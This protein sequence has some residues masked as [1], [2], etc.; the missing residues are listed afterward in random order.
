MSH[1]FA[2]LLVHLRRLSLAPAKNIETDSALLSRFV[3]HGDTLAFELLFW[4]HGPMVW[5]VCRRFLGNAADAED[6]FQATFLVLA[7]KARSV[8]NGAALSGWLHRV[9]RHTALNARKAQS[10]R[11]VRER[12]T[13]ALSQFSSQGDISGEASENE[14][15]ALIDEEIAL[16]PEKFRLPL[17]LCDMEARTHESAAAELGCPLGTLNSRLARGREKLKERLARHGVTSTALSGVPVPMNLATAALHAVSR[18]PSA[19]VQALAQTVMWSLTL[20]AAKKVGAVMAVCCVL[21]IGIASGLAAARS[22]K[23]QEPT[24][25]T[26]FPAVA[27]A[28]PDEKLNFIDPDAGPLPADAVARIG[29]LRLRHAGEVTGLTYSP[30]GKWLA[31]ISASPNDATA[32]VWD[33]ANGKEQLRVKVVIAGEFQPRF[34]PLAF[35]FGM[36]LNTFLVADAGSIRSFDI[37]TGKA[38]FAHRMTYDTA[39]NLRGAGFTPDGKTIVL[40]VKDGIEIMDVATGNVRIKVDQPFSG[41][42]IPIEFSKDSSTF[43]LCIRGSNGE[44]GKARAVYETASGR[45]IASIDTDGKFLHQFLFSPKGEILAG[46]VQVTSAKNW[47]T[48]VE[49]FEVKTGKHLRSVDV[50]PTTDVIAITPDEKYLVAG[51]GQ[52]RS[53][54]LIDFATGKEA[55]RI[56]SQPSVSYLAFS[57]DGKLLAGARNGAGAITV[58]DMVNRRLHPMAPEPANYFGTTFSQDGHSLVLPGRGRLLVDW[59]TG[60]AIRRFADVELDLMVN[61][62]LSPDQSLY[63]V[64]DRTGN[65]PIQLVDAKT[66]KEIRTLTGHTSFAVRMVFS[67][68]SRRLAACSYD[69]AI[70]VWDVATGREVG[71]FTT[72]ENQGLDGPSLSSD[73]RILAA[74]SNRRTDAGQDNLLYTWD[75]DAKV[76]LARIEA[77]QY[78]NYPAPLSP[79]GRFVASV[80]GLAPGTKANSDSCVTIWNAVTGRALQTLPRHSTNWMRP[81]VWCS[82]SPT[83]QWLATGDSAGHLRLWEVLSGQEVYHF[84]GHRTFV[85]MNFSPAGRYLVAVSEDAPCFIW[86][87]IGSSAPSSLNLWVESL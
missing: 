22:G 35:S 5:G 47:T 73:G 4:R 6:A 1:V 44:Q 51:N 67:A 48:M 8:G 15:K 24:V 9:A 79:D 55:G 86:D 43:A 69:K 58:W 36:E 56:Q 59:R 76:Q 49:F 20:T 71:Q 65:G 37:A 16:L 7:S 19:P 11:T 17:I 30:D 82:F 46:L 29:S 62:V 53:S 32:R 70:R 54:Q 45:Q 18:A 68:D 39:K 74:S 57:P 78:V 31:S 10:R 61:T 21:A 81:G 26:P 14:H 52:K 13:S 42:G 84:E 77:H 66:G 23:E 83:S 72:Q 38:S 85:A 28:I 34:E 87:L 12:P 50:D 25:S 33:A 27:Q 3:K 80:S 2:N 60:K 64:P 75:V 40:V 41:H 63:A